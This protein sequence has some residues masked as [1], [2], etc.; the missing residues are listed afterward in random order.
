MNCPK[1]ETPME[2]GLAEIHG[3]SSGFL[4]FGKSYQ[5]L[6]FTD[7]EGNESKVLSPD[8]VKAALR[9]KKC[10]GLFISN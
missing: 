5:P 6:F 4:I 7:S 3:T 1:C 9:C 2:R 10:G 8:T